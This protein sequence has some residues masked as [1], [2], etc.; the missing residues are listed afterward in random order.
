MATATKQ[1]Y[2]L[3]EI[4]E[5]WGVSHSTVLS[6]VY[7]GDL[8]AID[9]STNPKGKSRY[10]VPADSLADFEASRTTA[11]PE[12]PETRKRVHVPAGAVIEFFK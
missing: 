5:R 2:T 3:A 12:K 10:I 11:P 8:R 4:A 6:L 1:H 7:G 9:I